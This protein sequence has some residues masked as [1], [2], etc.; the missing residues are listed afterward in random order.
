LTF[1]RGSVQLRDRARRNL[2]NELDEAIEQTERAQDPNQVDH[3][4]A[5]PSLDPLQ[6]RH[7]DPRFMCEVSLSEIPG[8]AGLA[9][10]SA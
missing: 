5:V 9:Q 10:A 2:G 3:R 6:G 7:S 4:R 1:A 8:Q